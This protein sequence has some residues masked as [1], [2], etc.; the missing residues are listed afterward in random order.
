MKNIRPSVKAIRSAFGEYTTETFAGYEITA[1]DLMKIG[2]LQFMFDTLESI[3]PYAGIYEP[4][5]HYDESTIE[6]YIV[7]HTQLYQAKA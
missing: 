3:F 7:R 5:E 6:K 4:F 2:G 1:W